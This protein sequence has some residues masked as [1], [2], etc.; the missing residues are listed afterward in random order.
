MLFASYY[1]WIAPHVLLGVFLIC[2]LGR[3]LHRQLPIFFGYVVFQLLQFIVL[4][5]IFLHSPFR[6]DI[7][8]WTLVAGEGVG[9]ILELGVIYELANQLLLSR[10]T[11]GLVLRRAL[12]AILA[13]LVLGAAIGSGAFSGISVQRV[14]NIF[15]VVNFSSNLIEAG[16]VL[17]LFIF[18]HALRISWNSWIAGVALGFG[19]S[20]SIDLISA[21]LRAQ[22]GERAFVAVDLTQM[23]SFH[24]CVVIWLVYLFLA[25]RGPSFPDGKLKVSDLELWDQELQRMVQR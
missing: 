14:V 17:T 19:I 13:L 10:S 3:G 24:V 7:Y 11:A 20:A 4:F 25:D 8:K 22:W 9:S 1:L 23:A 16:M 2:L 5:T 12:Q 18:A 6:T 21:A 15:E